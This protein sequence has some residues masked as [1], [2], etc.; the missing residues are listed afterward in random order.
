[1]KIRI[2]RI[3]FVRMCLVIFL[4][5]FLHLLSSIRTS[6]KCISGVKCEA[7]EVLQKVVDDGNKSIYSKM[8]QELGE[9]NEQV[10]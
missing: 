7:L 5:V 10:P 8:I 9:C 4:L 6:L 3:G 1:M 2:V